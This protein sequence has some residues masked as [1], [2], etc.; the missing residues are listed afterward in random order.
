MTVQGARV[1]WYGLGSMGLGMALNLT[2]HLK[3]AGAPPLRYSN[4]TLEKGKP[5]AEAGALPEQNYEAVVNASDIVFTMACISNDQVLKELTSVAA[6]SCTSIAGKIFVDTSTV[7]PD[8]SASVSATLAAKGATFISSPVFGA[9]PMAASGKLIFAMAGPSAALTAVKP[10][11]LNV[12][13]RSIIDMGDDVRKSSLLKISGNILVISFMEVIAEAQV[14]AEVTGIGCTQMEEFIG[15]MF[16][17]VLESYSHRMTSGAWAPPHGTP[18]GFAASLAAKDARHALSIANSN[19]MRIPTMDT[20]LAHLKLA[21]S[22]AG[23]M[24]DSSAV[25][26]CLRAQAGLPF[27]SENSRKEP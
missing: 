6:E 11:V 27:W 12:M 19:D 18:P 4:R 21:R 13:G 5:L 7:H 9:S 8:T 22:H 25:Y 23:D 2:R 26:G 14:F 15:N 10:L 3:S 16:G 20:A 17:P 24:I 1:G